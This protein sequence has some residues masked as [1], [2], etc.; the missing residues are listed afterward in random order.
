MAT[1]FC[2]PACQLDKEYI[3]DIQFHMGVELMEAGVIACN[4]YSTPSYHSNNVF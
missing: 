3:E 2:L 4:L 1:H